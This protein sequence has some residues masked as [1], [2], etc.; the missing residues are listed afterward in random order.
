MKT[1][2]FGHGSDPSLDRFPLG[3]VF[4]SFIMGTHEKR[5]LRNA[6]SLV[7]CVAPLVGLRRTH[8]WILLD[9]VKTWPTPLTI[10]HLSPLTEPLFCYLFFA[11]NR[12]TTHK[13]CKQSA[14]DRL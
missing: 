12:Y 14:S 13:A 9:N 2:E 6:S 7:G 4:L 8:Q 1:Y 5:N 3:R 10:H 11:G